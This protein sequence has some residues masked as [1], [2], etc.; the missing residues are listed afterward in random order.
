MNVLGIS[1]HSYDSSA[2][3]VS[4]GRVVASSTEERFTRQSHD[5][6]FP[7]F[8]VE[9]CLEKGGLAA[10]ELDAVVFFEEPHGKFSRIMTSSLAGFPGSGAGFIRNAKTW[11]EHK[12]WVREEISKK[13]DLHPKKI[14]FVP[15]H[16]S[17]AAQA[18]VGSPFDEA[19]VL[20]VDTVG[21][22]V[23]TSLCSGSYQDGRLEITEHEN[24]PYPHSL[25]LVVGAFTDLLGF[26]VDEGESDVRDLAA[27]GD[28]IY[29]SRMR[30]VIQVQKD[31]TY[32]VDPSYFRFENFAER[33]YGV[34]WR[35]RVRD[36][37]GPPRDARQ[38]F[39]FL[40]VPLDGERHES[41]SP[42]DKRFADIAHSLQVV[43]EEAV[44]ALC[45]RIHKLTGQDRLCLSGRLASNP[46]LVRK[47]REEGPFKDLYI[48]PDP[49]EGGCAEGAALLVGHSSDGPARGGSWVAAP[50]LGKAYDVT[51]DVDSVDSAN[52]AYWQ[53][54][55]KRGTRSIHG[56]EIENTR[57]ESFEAMLG[58][59]VDDLH[60]GRIVGW[61]Q[62]PSESSPVALGNRSILMDPSSVETARRLSCQVKGRPLFSPYGL[63]V[64]DKDAHRVLDMD[65]LH[66][67]PTWLL[68][69]QSNARVNDEVIPA[70][71]ATVH[72]D[73]TTRPMVVTANSNR[74]FYDLLSAYGERC[75]LSALLNTGF[76][77]E[78]FPL[79]GSPADALLI[80]MR[81]ELDSLVLENTLIRKVLT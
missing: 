62:G 17:Q 60:Q 78:D 79:A 25:G 71:R 41:I 15:R 6:N 27:Y 40:S 10:H 7:Q 45:E 3:L 30:N 34:P 57:Y 5:P 8:A 4:D 50:Y 55:R 67:V 54:F 70:V 73:G 22:W 23:S 39:P 51:R 52:P 26:R 56:M 76:N 37:F 47:V 1:A 44:L 36:R 11:L 35:R 64:T 48:P 42:E 31:G 20:V 2:A 59:V 49:G 68:W 12:L 33:P 21:E 13:L 72:V 16:Q 32:K 75:G 69:M 66:P 24:I 65:G 19:A 29:V 61:Y 58:H 80:F 43:T 28:P 77:E 46:A 53:R 14:R 9:F 74:R 18:F 63:A 81:T 38:P